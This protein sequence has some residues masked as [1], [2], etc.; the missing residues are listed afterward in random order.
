MKEGESV[1]DSGWKF[2]VFR[3]C[4]WPPPPPLF[5]SRLFVIFLIEADLIRTEP[6]SIV[7]LDL[8]ET[9]SVIALTQLLIN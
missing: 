8:A 9:I 4:R 7:K 6:V 2:R 3:H 1:S 5:S